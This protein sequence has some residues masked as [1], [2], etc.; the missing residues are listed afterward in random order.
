M[1]P[2]HLWQSDISSAGSPAISGKALKTQNSLYTLALMCRLS[3]AVAK[4]YRR[5]K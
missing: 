1:C 5:T 4:I 2:P 3:L